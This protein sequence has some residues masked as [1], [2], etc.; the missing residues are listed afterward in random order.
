[1]KAQEINPLLHYVVFGINEHRLPSVANHTARP[2]PP[3]ATGR[4]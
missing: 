4:P 1:V 2:R 3:D